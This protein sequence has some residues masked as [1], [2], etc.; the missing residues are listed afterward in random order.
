MHKQNYKKVDHAI[1]HW[2]LKLKAEETPNIRSWR[3]I[4]AHDISVKHALDEYLK[5]KTV[6]A[7]M[8]GHAIRRKEIAYRQV[9]FLAQRLAKAGYLIVSGGGAGIMEAA[10]LGG[11]MM[12]RSEADLEEALKLLVVNGD[13]FEH[14]YEN[15]EAADTVIKRF[16]PAT[17][18]PSLGLST[19]HYGFTEP[20]NV[21]ASFHAKI[22]SNA[23][24]EDL[25]TGIA[26]GAIVFNPGSAGTMQEVF[27]NACFNHYSDPG[28]ESPTIFLNRQFWEPHHAFS[29]LKAQSTGKPYASLLLMSDDSDEIVALVEKHRKAKNLPL[30]TPDALLRPWWVKKTCPHQDSHF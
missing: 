20:S 1:H 18:M 25:V 27:Q 3:A 8:G 5:G 29:L 19:W 28:K 22:F 30:I 11:Y 10:N 23:L 26:N 14:E 4:A 9:A 12:E 17:H 6:I 2:F 13:K 7:F 21:F 16:G 24:R 15:T